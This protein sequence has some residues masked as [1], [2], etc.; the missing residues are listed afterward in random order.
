MEGS[1]L[2]LDDV[3]IALCYRVVATRRMHAGQLCLHS[4]PARTCDNTVNC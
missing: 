1:M 4:A 3:R 2:E